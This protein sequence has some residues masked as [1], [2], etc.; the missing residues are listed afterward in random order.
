[1]F[2][3]RLSLCFVLMT[4]SVGAQSVFRSV[5]SDDT[6]IAP[7]EPSHADSVT[8]I[9]DYTSQ[10]VF[11]FEHWYGLL[12]KQDI[13]T[14]NPTQVYA[15]WLIADINIHE[16]SNAQFLAHEILD[17][18]NWTDE[19]TWTNWGSGITRLLR[20][21]VPIDVEMVL[22]GDANLDGVVDAEDL[23]R[24]ALHWGDTSN[25][26][27]FEADFNGDGVVDSAD[28]NQIGI[29]W[30][31]QVWIDQPAEA[32]ILRMNF[33]ALFWA[34]VHDDNGFVMF[35]NAS[36]PGEFV[37]LH[38]TEAPAALSPRFYINF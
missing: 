22:S 29:N 19:W 14:L 36:A 13:A 26:G 21:V 6:W 32:A 17:G 20:G 3:G 15:R 10:I 1:M 18:P 37:S 34:G 23:N 27:W 24:L 35:L 4:S 8:V 16:N 11:D 12:T 38:S 25:V 33:W 5:L 2:M 31:K 7:G 30:H 28:L 9:E